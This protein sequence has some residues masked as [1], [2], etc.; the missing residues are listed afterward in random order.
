MAGAGSESVLRAPA[1]LLQA[2]SVAIVGAS[3][4]ARWASQIYANL[5][6]F[7]YGGRIVLVNPRQQKVFGEDCI[8]SLRD[9]SAPVDHAMVIVPAPHV[10]D[11]LADAEAAGVKSAT[12]YASAVGDGES[13][14]SRQ[15]GA[16]DWDTTLLPTSTRSRKALS[17]RTAWPWRIAARCSPRSV[18]SM[19]RSTPAKTWS[20]TTEWPEPAC[21]AS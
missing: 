1:S 16:H 4:R 19:N 7:G 8:P 14:P 20:S 10:P 6:E 18:F 15:R 17:N 5:R 21:A 13:E 2:S 9:L 11:V 12:V 3:E